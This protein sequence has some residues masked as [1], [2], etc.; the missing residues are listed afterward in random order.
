MGVNTLEALKGTNYTA[1]VVH[2][3]EGGYTV[4]VRK[5]GSEI[6]PYVDYELLGVRYI[7][8][9]ATQRDLERA[10]EDILS[11]VSQSLAGVYVGEQVE[12]SEGVDIVSV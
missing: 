5:P 10:V 6:D 8:E 7:T 9:P 3:T 11:K 12:E 1:L 4:E 2:D